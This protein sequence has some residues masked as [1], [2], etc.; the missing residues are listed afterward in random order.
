[1]CSIPANVRAD[2]PVNIARY[3][4]KYKLLRSPEFVRLGLEAI[5]ERTCK[6]R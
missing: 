5:Y 3:V 2:G 1:M 6:S 4:S